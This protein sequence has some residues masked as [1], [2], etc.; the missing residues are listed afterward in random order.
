LSNTSASAPATTTA[1][2]TKSKENPYIK[3]GIGKCYRC[4]K[5]GHSSN[6][7]PNRKQVNNADYGDE[8]EGIIIEEASDSDFAKEKKDPLACVISATRSYP[9]PHND[10]N[11]LF[12][13]FGK[14]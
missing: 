6:E 9:A 8:E 13:V 2:V 14:E 12:K 7:C 5:P 3:P 11:L 10:T 1:T 4:E